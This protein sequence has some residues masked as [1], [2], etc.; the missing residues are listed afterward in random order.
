MVGYRQ[1]IFC[2]NFHFFRFREEDL[3][4]RERNL[5]PSPSVAAGP[6]GLDVSDDASSVASSIP[7]RESRART[8][9]ANR[10]VESALGGET[11]TPVVQRSQLVLPQSDVTSEI[12]VV[13]DDDNNNDT[14]RLVWNLQFSDLK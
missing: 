14:R 8:M 5:S 12:N 10:Q 7:R 11:S 4:R 13:S 3:T 9:A 2:C 6:E 1:V